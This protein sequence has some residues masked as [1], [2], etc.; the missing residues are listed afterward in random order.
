MCAPALS[1]LGLLLVLFSLSGRG[2]AHP[3]GQAT[4]SPASLQH[5]VSVV[6]KLIRVFVTD[7]KGNPVAGLAKSDFELFDDGARVE[8]TDFENHVSDADA[9]KGDAA[10][11]AP[12]SDRPNPAS[13]AS[14]PLMARKFILLFDFA[15][16]NPRGIVQAKAAA[17]HF[18]ET[19]L[20]PEDE[21]GVISLS[22]SRGLAVHETLTTRHD[23]VGKAVEAVNVKAAAGRADE[24]EEEYWR[25]QGEGSANPR[26]GKSLF[27]LNA[28]RQD[29]KAQASLFLDMMIELAGALRHVAGPK[30][31]LLFST[32]LPESLIYGNRMNQYMVFESGG[33]VRTVYDPGDSIL[34]RKNESMLKEFAAAGCSLFS[35][36][37]REAAM[38]PS[39][40]NYDS[41][42]LEEGNR[43]MFTAQGAAQNAT[44]VFKDDK[45]TGL[46]ALRKAAGATGG[47]YFPNIKEY[48]SSLARV[49]AM[50]DNYYVLGYR[51][52][53][54][55]D[56]RFHKIRVR[57]KAK[58]YTVRTQ[59]GYYNPKPFKDYSDLEKR[60]HLVDLALSQAPAARIPIEPRISGLVY[61]ENENSLV[62]L[63]TKV[64]PEV[65]LSILGRRIEFVSL[66]F[67]GQDKIAWTDR[68]E[69]VSSEKRDR[70]ALHI[71]EA[72]LGPGPYR[73]RLIL[74]DMESGE[75]GISSLDLTVKDRPAFGLAV[76]TPLIFVDNEPPLFIG[77]GDGNQPAKWREH[78]GMDSEGLSPVVGPLPGGLSAIGVAFACSYWDLVNPDLV[79]S[80]Q[81]ID[82]STGKEAP[83]PLLSEKTAAEQSRIRKVLDFSANDLRPG[84]YFFYVRA[85][86]KASN[87]V[88]FAQTTLIIQS[89]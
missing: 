78:Y 31:I 39:L 54:R 77:T 58:G 11:D 30:E 82:S 71:T 55:Q 83:F 81:L 61:T 16:N 9:P 1:A 85:R 6:L 49:R 88:A 7:D 12:G 45:L 84:T 19:A 32:G 66:I 18:L 74:R 87:S 8:I 47:E 17:R 86:D 42:T 51:L 73:C 52:S 36:D 29:S 15:Y 59:T 13:A 4:R 50:T 26:G 14:D 21:A 62:T 5:D 2:A 40:F 69:K 72:K 65:M 64:P 46:F 44:Q 57:V 60:L 48:E 63:F 34:I 67:D 80:Y 22:M 56:G 68:V 25:R 53:E 33:R 28:E 37:T 27:Q 10:S 41:Q 23:L 75:S 79:F 38:I 43:N 35:F 20:R 76:D 89:P 24:I 70:Q 3:F